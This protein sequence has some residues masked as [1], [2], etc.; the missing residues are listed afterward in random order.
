[1]PHQTTTDARVIDDALECQGELTLELFDWWDILKAGRPAPQDY[2]FDHLDRP[3]LVKH[4]ILLKAPQG[5]S[6]LVVKYTG[7]EVTR[8]F[9]RDSMSNTVNDVLGEDEGDPQWADYNSN[10]QIIIDLCRKEVRPVL[11]GPKLLNFP[12]GNYRRF[13]SLT[14]PF[15]DETGTVTLTA[16]IFDLLSTSSV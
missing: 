9:G 12:L 1:M 16:S 10:T 11:N 5:S 15:V 13:E 6:D 8:L 3:K 7:A 4:L 2:E 14:V